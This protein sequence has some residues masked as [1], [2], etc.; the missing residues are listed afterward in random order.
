M[1]KQVY[2]R[3]KTSENQRMTEKRGGLFKEKRKKQ[4]SDPQKNG[5]GAKLEL[6]EDV[7]GGR[8]N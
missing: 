6:I 4:R 2:R 7:K 5:V 3:L 8:V 1:A